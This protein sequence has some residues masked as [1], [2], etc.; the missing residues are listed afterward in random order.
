MRQRAPMMIGLFASC[1]KIDNR[2]YTVG[3][4]QKDRNQIA[5]AR[6]QPSGCSSAEEDNVQVLGWNKRVWRRPL[7][8]MR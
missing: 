5:P 4:E 8:P 3:D 6:G 1:F 2:W 7:H